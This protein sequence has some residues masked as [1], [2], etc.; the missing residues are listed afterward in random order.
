MYENESD[1]SLIW[2]LDGNMTNLSDVNISDNSIYPPHP[3]PPPPPQPVSDMPD[4]IS[5]ARCLP[6]VATYNLRSLLPK[7]GSLTTDILE[8]KIDC[9]FLS[10]IWEQ[11]DNKNHQ[12]EIEKL[13]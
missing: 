9:G 12:F 6:V 13:L 2:Q 4:R 1:I 7:I 3:L 5:A 11:D 8:R 10:E